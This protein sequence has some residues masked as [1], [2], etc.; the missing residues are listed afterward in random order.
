MP[1]WVKE[2]YVDYTQYRQ[3]YFDLKRRYKKNPKTIRKYFDQHDPVVGE[4]LVSEHSI[5]AVMDATF[6]NRLDGVLVCRA[7]QRN[8][9]WKYISSE[10]M[11]EYSLFLDALDASGAVFHSFTIDGRRGVKQLLEKRYGAIPIQHCQFHQVQTI[12]QKLTKNPKLEASKALRRIALTITKA[13]RLEFTEQLQQWHME[14]A[15]F[16]QEKTYN[17]DPTRKRRWRYTHER[18]RSAFFSLRRN[19]PY[20]FTYLDYPYLC[21]PNTTNSCDGSFSHWKK[22]VSLHRGIHIHRRNKMINF[23]LE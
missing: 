5:S 21:I 19:L 8:V 12:T 2:A 10:S 17:E 11:A 6:F 18:L 16:L 14:W 22:K 7:N 4:I 15:G 13:T 1:P 9:Y 20:L 23:L 3:T